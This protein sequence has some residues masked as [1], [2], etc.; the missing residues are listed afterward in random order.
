[1]S[2]SDILVNVV[3]ISKT[4]N[5]N[6]SHG[7]D[8]VN[9]IRKYCYIIGYYNK[10]QRSIVKLRAYAVHRACKDLLHDGQAM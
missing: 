1:M 2:Y 5:V 6:V 7:E 9:R 10:L 3:K 8:I 4:V